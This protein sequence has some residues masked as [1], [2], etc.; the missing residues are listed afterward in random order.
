MQKTSSQSSKERKRKGGEAGV[1]VK[2][3]PSDV[4]VYIIPEGAG[5]KTSEAHGEAVLVGRILSSEPESL[6]DIAGG[7]IQPASGLA[8]REMIDL[9]YGLLDHVEKKIEVM[10]KDIDDTSAKISEGV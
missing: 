6:G 7:V 10:S 9:M 4:P 2:V 5:F 1:S 8:D 3:L